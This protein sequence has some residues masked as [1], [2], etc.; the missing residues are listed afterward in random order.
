MC[1]VCAVLSLQLTTAVVCTF[2]HIRNLRN[3]WLRTSPTDNV[4]KDNIFHHNKLLTHYPLERYM[5]TAP[6]TISWMHYSPQILKISVEILVTNRFLIQNKNTETIYI[7]IIQN[8]LYLWT[9]DP[10]VIVGVLVETNQHGHSR[11]LRTHTDNQIYISYSLIQY[12]RVYSP[13]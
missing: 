5:W 4:C 6:Q 11:T 12:Y 9:R 7:Q 8:W 2:I 13:R 3:L 10:F 1:I